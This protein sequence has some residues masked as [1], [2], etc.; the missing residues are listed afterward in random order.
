MNSP[1][2][3]DDAIGYIK[4]E[5]GLINSFESTGGGASAVVQCTY[6][7]VKVVKRF[8][9]CYARPPM[10]LCTAYGFFFRET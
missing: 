3:T 9:T 10:L 5:H 2:V 1:Y 4:R 7:V 8:A 6:R